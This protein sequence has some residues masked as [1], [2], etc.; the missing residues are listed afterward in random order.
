MEAVSGEVIL[1]CVRWYLRFP[2]SYAHV[3]E[4]MS[5]RGLLVD[6]SCVWRWVQDYAPQINKR[7][8]PH[9]K[10]VNRSWR[11]DETYIKVKGK[12]RYLYRPV[13]STG[14]TIDFLLTAKR[15]GESSTAGH[16]CRQEPRVSGRDRTT[17]GRMHPAPP[18]PAA[19]M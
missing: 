8:R 13:D 6:R 11:V 1:L 16:Q 19:P 5:E 10:P 7:C 3:A 9:L 18:L 14:Q 12:D 15:D 4:I 2:L 17:P